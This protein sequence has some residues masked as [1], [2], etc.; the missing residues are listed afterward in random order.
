MI[1][2]R[3]RSPAPHVGVDDGSARAASR[4]RPVG[5]R[6]ET[7]HCALKLVAGYYAIDQAVLQRLLGGEEAVSFHVPVDPLDALAGVTRI[8]RIDMAA[9]VEDLPRV[10]LDVGGL[11]LDSRPTAGG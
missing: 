5:A 4:V 10:D 11:S 7:R 3:H 2:S 9:Q 8:D 6:G 1:V